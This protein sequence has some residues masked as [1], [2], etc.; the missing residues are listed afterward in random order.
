M[1]AHLTTYMVPKPPE[2]SLI[3]MDDQAEVNEKQVLPSSCCVTSQPM[4]GSPF[5]AVGYER[6]SIMPQEQKEDAQQEKRRDTKPASGGG[7]NG[8]PASDHPT[9]HWRSRLTLNIV[10]DHFL[11]DKTHLPADVHRYLKV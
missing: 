10:A 11:F 7:A 5:E 3:S 8:R 6:C 9:S 2:I 1:V 4:H